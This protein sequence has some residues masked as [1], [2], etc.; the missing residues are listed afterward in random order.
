MLNKVQ[1]RRGINDFQY[2]TLRDILKIEG[3]RTKEFVEKCREVKVR[4]YKEK[5]VNVFRRHMI[6]LDLKNLLSIIRY[7]YLLYSYLDI[8]HQRS[9][10]AYIRCILQG[11]TAELVLVLSQMGGYVH[12]HFGCSSNSQQNLPSIL[13]DMQYFSNMGNSICPEQL[14]VF[15]TTQLQHICTGLVLGGCIC[16]MDAVQ[17]L[18]KI[19]CAVLNS[20]KLPIFTIQYP[21]LQGL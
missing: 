5:F 9:V 8:P 21:P 18:T 20:P 3:E 11:C 1:K 4:I 15:P 13:N 10:M 7:W 19:F 12:L 16:I 2:F 17:F 6:S 14:H